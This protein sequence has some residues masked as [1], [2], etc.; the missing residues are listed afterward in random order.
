[1]A[2]K[3]T[4]S[5]SFT[6]LN[7]DLWINSLAGNHGPWRTYRMNVG[8]PI[9]T[10]LADTFANDAN[11]SARTT[12]ILG[13]PTLN[14]YYTLPVSWLTAAAS[15]SNINLSWPI[16]SAATSDY[17]IYHATSLTP[18]AWTWLADVGPTIDGWTHNSPGTGSH[19]YLIK[20]MAVKTTGSGSYT[21]LSNGTLSNGV[22]L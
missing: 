10:M 8:A 9:Y 22:T 18:A 16:Q 20:S 4:G 12:Y 3:S 2:I 11:A 7:V 1:M 17:H 5:G 21:N 6:N 15:G 14:E 13:D 19:A